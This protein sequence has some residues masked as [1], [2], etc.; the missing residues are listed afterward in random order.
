MDAN[1]KLVQHVNSAKK[2]G[3]KK[4]SIERAMRANEVGD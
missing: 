3:V 2:E 1:P 4:E